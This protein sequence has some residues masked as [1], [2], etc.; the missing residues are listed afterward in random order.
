VP[1]RQ[2]NKAVPERLETLIMDCVKVRAEDRPDNMHIVA[3]KLDLILGI[4][5][6]AAAAAIAPTPASPAATDEKN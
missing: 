1:V 3:D 6:A 2:I 5:R 4:V